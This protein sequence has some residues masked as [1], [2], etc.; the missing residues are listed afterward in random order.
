MSWF[1]WSLLEKHKEDSALRSGNGRLSSSPSRL[2]KR[3]FLYGCRY[4]VV[5]A[6]QRPAQLGGP[7]AEI[8]CVPDSWIDGTRLVPPV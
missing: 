2:A 1:D 6:K 5:R 3:N 4:Q 7:A 8:D